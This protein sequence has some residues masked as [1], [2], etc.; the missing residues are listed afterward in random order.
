VICAAAKLA[1]GGAGSN[2][3]AGWGARQQAATRMARPEVQPVVCDRKL[4]RGEVVGQKAQPVGC[5]PRRGRAELILRRRIE[6]CARAPARSCNRGTAAGSQNRS[7]AWLSSGYAAEGACVRAEFFRG[8]LVRQGTP[9][10]VRRRNAPVHG[11]ARAQ[12]I[13]LFTRLSRARTHISDFLPVAVCSTVQYWQSS[14][15]PPRAVITDHAILG[16]MASG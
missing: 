7:G 11:D 12:M 16:P 2:N 4:P 5:R 1:R 13:G 8:E 10:Q 3:P 14:A 9:N 6:C 15:H